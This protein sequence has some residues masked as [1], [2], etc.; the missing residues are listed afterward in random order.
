M[1]QSAGLRIENRH[2]PLAVFQ[3]AAHDKEFS[4]GMKPERFHQS[5]SRI[6]FVRLTELFAV[7]PVKTLPELLAV[8][9]CG[10][11]RRTHAG[12]VKFFIVCCEVQRV[13]TTGVIMALD[14]SPA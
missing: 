5:A 14:D 3:P 1:Q 11:G 2:A 9:R 13:N 10:I 8:P 7:A 12:G 6:T 4:G